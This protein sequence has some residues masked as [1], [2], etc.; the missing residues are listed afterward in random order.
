[1]TTRYTPI[2]IEGTVPCTGMDLY[3]LRHTYWNEDGNPLTAH[4][5]LSP[6]ASPLLRVHFDNVHIVRVLAE[7]Y[8][9]T[10]EYGFTP[11]GLVPYH[12]A[13]RVEGSRFLLSQSEF[14]RDTQRDAVHYRFVTAG[15]CLDVL[16]NREPSCMLVSSVA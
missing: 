7:L 16:T 14:C 11:E 9:D 12:F 5:S 1:M 2:A 4:F 6:E 8:L 15:A 13:Y 3:D 10:E